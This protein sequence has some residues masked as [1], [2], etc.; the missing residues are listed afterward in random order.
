[1]KISRD[2]EDRHL[3]SMSQ[4]KLYRIYFEDQSFDG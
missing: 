3:T 4:I 2:T 1:M